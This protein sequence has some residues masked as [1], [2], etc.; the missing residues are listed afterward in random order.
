MST[1]IID[2]GNTKRG[3]HFS[4]T[5]D[6]VSTMNVIEEGGIK[7][8][9]NKPNTM[10][11]H[12]ASDPRNAKLYQTTLEDGTTQLKIGLTGEENEAGQPLDLDVIKSYL[13]S[14][15]GALSSLVSLTYVFESADAVVSTKDAIENAK[16]ITKKYNAETDTENYVD[17]TNSSVL[18]SSGT[19]KNVVNYFYAGKV[20]GVTDTYFIMLN[21]FRTELYQDLDPIGGHSFA[22]TSSGGE[23][24]RSKLITPIVSNATLVDNDVIL[25]P[26]NELTIDM[27]SK[28]SLLTVG[29]VNFSVKTNCERWE[30]ADNGAFKFVIG[31]RETAYVSIA[32]PC[33]P[34]LDLDNRLAVRRTFTIHKG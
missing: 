24:L 20:S 15:D 31:D 23:G 16:L 28:N 5:Q 27:F 25:A 21:G 12:S 3:Y 1:W 4:I 10:L 30:Q 29:N 11:V 2:H 34:A 8:V 17:I 18:W 13:D 14:A 6:N 33:T 7:K 26:K 9:L 32:I 22:Y 19:Q